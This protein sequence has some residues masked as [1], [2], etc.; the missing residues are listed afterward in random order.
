MH[1]IDYK[2]E[3]NELAKL[4]KFTVTLFD[5]F[6]KQLTNGSIKVN[7]NNLVNKPYIAYEQNL[8]S[9]ED[10]MAFNIMIEHAPNEKDLKLAAI[11]MAEAVFIKDKILGEFFDSLDSVED[12]KKSQIEVN[13]PTKV[14]L[15]AKKHGFDN[16]IQLIK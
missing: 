4:G 14:K 10:K 15:L 16:I 13:S 9:D 12:R 11:F 1:D 2:K 3:F 5:K 8:L 6:H 7:P